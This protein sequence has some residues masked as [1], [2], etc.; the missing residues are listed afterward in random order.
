MFPNLVN[1]GGIYTDIIAP[2]S[3]YLAFIALKKHTQE[4]KYILLVMGA[5]RLIN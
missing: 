3:T 2:A 1:Q 5:L 4:E